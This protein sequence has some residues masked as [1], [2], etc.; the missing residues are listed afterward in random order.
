MR[1]SKTPA[2]QH[3]SGRPG[4]SILKAPDE[5]V[6]M[7][8][9]VSPQTWLHYGKHQWARI[10][11][12]EARTTTHNASQGVTPPDAGQTPGA[13]A[14]WLSW[15]K[16]GG[17]TCPPKGD[18]HSSGFIQSIIEATCLPI[19]LS[20]APSTGKQWHDW[21]DKFGRRMRTVC[22]PREW[23]HFWKLKSSTLKKDGE[24]PVP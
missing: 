14:I 20:W 4:T 16:E 2:G 8:K 6:S 7:W 12:V 19:P 1:R 22:C 15:N 21:L 11:L 23:S 13:S 17:E 9:S 18:V 10:F 24:D 5:K 3:F